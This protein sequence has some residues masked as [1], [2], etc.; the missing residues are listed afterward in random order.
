[1]RRVNSKQT[2]GA[3]RHS[4]CAPRRTLL[5]ARSA[6]GWTLIELVVTM[7]VMVILTIGVLP[8][9]KTAVKRQRESQLREALRQM[10]ESIKDFQRD[11]VGMQCA[12]AVGGA[13]APNPPNGAGGQPAVVIDPRS[14]V[15][16]ADCTI[17]GVDNILRY[18]PSLEA[19]VEGVG[20]VPRQPQLG[21][22]GG[23]NPASGESS[24]LPTLGSG[25]LLANK[26]KIYLREIPVDPMTGKKDWCLHTPF[27]DADTCSD[28]TDAGLFDVTSRSDGTALDGTKYKDW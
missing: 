11:T 1:M 27:D 2:E 20:V 13:P 5:A 14:K 7:T 19:M 17:F 12:G 10:R 9:V 3:A 28:G 26:K 24:S 16:I 22:V 18:P 15:A 8:M 4:A 25:G 23:A 21:A 6:G